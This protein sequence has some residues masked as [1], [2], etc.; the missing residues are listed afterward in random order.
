[1]DTPYMQERLDEGFAP[2]VFDPATG[3]ETYLG[4]MK[5]Q[6]HSW[7]RAAG[8]FVMDI[9][10]DTLAGEIYIIKFNLT[11]NAAVSP[12]VAGMSIETSGIVAD[13]SVPGAG[14]VRL[15]DDDLRPLKVEPIMFNVT[16]ISQATRNPQPATLNTQHSTLLNTQHST[17]N[18]QHSTHSTLN[19][20]PS[21]PIPLDPNP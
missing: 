5:Y 10:N 12:G 21:P 7:D 17:L 3:E 1:M 4:V 11:Q 20:I 2:V 16:T 19:S 9:A 14:V 15:D 13:P 8:S 6:N 18:T